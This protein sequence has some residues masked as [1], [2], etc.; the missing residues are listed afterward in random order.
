[1]ESSRNNCKK[2]SELAQ[3]LE[4]MLTCGLSL[5]V[6]RRHI[7]L[8]PRTICRNPNT[9]NFDM[10]M[11]SIPLHLIALGDVA[12]RRAAKILK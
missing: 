1:L 5:S 9:Q 7:I 3:V 2:A 4:V 11:Q 8:Q 6:T 10:K 12:N